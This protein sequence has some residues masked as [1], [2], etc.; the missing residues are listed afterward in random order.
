MRP[1]TK[2]IG[3]LIVDMVASCETGNGISPD[4]TFTYKGLLPRDDP[5]V[6]EPVTGWPARLGRKSVG[7]KM[8]SPSDADESLTDQ[9][10]SGARAHPKASRRAWRRVRLEF[11]LD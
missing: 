2:E 10:D 9:A 3:S 5:I 7:S 1:A 6:T 4:G 11:G 8:I